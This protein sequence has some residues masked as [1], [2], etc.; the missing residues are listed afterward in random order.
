MA[1]RRMR[2]G[3]MNSLSGGDAIRGAQVGRTL[4]PAIEDEQLMAEQRG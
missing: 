4:A 2:A 3:L 1:E